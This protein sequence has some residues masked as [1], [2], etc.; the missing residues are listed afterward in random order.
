VVGT[1]LDHVSSSNVDGRRPSVLPGR[2]G[3]RDAAHSTAANR[4]TGRG[5]VG[6]ELRDSGGDDLGLGYNP[7]LRLLN[8][9]RLFELL[10][11]A[12]EM[13]FEERRPFVHNEMNVRFQGLS[14]DQLCAWILEHDT[15]EENTDH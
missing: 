9:L 15:D 13:W 2:G 10:A 7:L 8:R 4:T 6:R 11:I 1:D 12:L 3:D 5:Q 14:R